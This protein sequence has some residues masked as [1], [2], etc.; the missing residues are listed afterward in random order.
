MTRIFGLRGSLR[1]GREGQGSAAEQDQG[2]NGRD[3]H[4][5]RNGVIGANRSPASRA[6]SGR[7]NGVA[8]LTWPHKILPHP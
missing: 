2:V 5:D 4:S 8:I 3:D 7:N 6:S 1:S